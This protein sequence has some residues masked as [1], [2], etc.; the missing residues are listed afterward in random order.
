MKRKNKTKYCFYLINFFI[1]IFEFKKEEN[2]LSKIK[3]KCEGYFAS[4]K[5]LKELG[6]FS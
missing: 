5:K 1:G 6:D 3:N 2:Q 4:K